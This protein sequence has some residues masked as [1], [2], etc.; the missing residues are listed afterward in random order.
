MNIDDVVPVYDDT[1]GAFKE[2]F[3]DFFQRIGLIFYLKVSCFASFSV[4]GLDN[5]IKELIKILEAFD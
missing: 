4:G 3:G 1:L 5:F 2:A